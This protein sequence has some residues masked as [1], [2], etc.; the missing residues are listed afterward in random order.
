MPD[1]D[2]ELL[3]L[4]IKEAVSDGFAEH[5][6]TDHVP[7]EERL[8]STRKL[9]WTGLGGVAVLGALTKMLGK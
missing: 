4:L 7:M 3:R 6:K 5:R 9:V 2:R 8:D 1:D